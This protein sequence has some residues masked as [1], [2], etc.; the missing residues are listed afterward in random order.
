MAKRRE[1]QEQQEVLADKHL[2][3]IAQRALHYWHLFPP[4]VKAYFD[5]EDLI[6]EVVLQV[7]KSS[8]RFNPERAQASTFVWW[9]ADNHCKTLLSRYSTMKHTSMVPLEEE[10]RQFADPIPPASLLRAMDGVES[11][12]ADAGNSP[13][14]IMEYL[15]ALF[16]GIRKR[17]WPEEIR[18]EFLSLARKHHVNYDDFRLVLSRI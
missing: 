5:A 8:R 10:L 11:L 14:G 12:L 1:Q 9:V 18:E 4:G 2:G 13:S 17:N 16:T 7:V 15:E 3:I 6:S